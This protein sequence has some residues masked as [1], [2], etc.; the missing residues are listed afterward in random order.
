MSFNILSS[1]GNS[2]HGIAP[3]RTLVKL[4][5]SY[6]DGHAEEQLK[7]PASRGLGHQGI[8]LFGILFRELLDISDFIK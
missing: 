7:P 6:W 3:H 2:L 1:S 8:H 4:S 5:I